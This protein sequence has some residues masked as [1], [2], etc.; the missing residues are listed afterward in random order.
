MRENQFLVYFFSRKKI[1]GSIDNSNSVTSIQNFSHIV[2]NSSVFFFQKKKIVEKFYLKNLFY[3]KNFFIIYCKPVLKLLLPTTT[4]I[5]LL[6]KFRQYA[7]KTEY[8]FLLCSIK[9]KF[10]KVLKLQN[11]F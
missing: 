6:C 8:I 1:N 2:Q 4:L 5:K 9:K 3:F 11:W 7:S 10:N